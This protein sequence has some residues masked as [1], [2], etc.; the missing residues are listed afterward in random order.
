[1]IIMNK[2]NKV[3]QTTDTAGKAIIKALAPKKNLI[4]RY[5]KRR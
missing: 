2:S 3:I 4:S 1:M 5:M